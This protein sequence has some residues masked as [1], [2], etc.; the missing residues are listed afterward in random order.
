MAVVTTDTNAAGSSSLWTETQNNVGCGM[1][2]GGTTGFC[3]ALK[4]RRSGA[5]PC[6][7]TN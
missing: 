3:A 6:F 2:A 7:F 5:R 4:E 1:S